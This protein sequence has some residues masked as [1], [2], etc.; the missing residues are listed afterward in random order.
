M[1]ILA[2]ENSHPLVS[3]IFYGNYFMGVLGILLSV[4]TC[5]QLHL[6]LNDLPFYLFLLTSVLFYYTYSYQQSSFAVKK[7]NPRTVWYIRHHQYIQWAQYI[8]IVILAV[9]TVIS[10][11]YYGKNIST[12]PLHLWVFTTLILL[13]AVLYYGLLP[14]KIW[15]INL[16]N[17]GWFKAFTIG[18]VWAGTVSIFPVIMLYLEGKKIHVEMPLLY[19]YFMKNFMFCTVNAIMFDLKDF[20]DDSNKDLLTFV[21]RFGIERTKYFILLPLACLGII[22]LTGFNYYEQYP[23]WHY[24]FNLIPF[25]LLIWTICSVDKNKT[26][27]YY[28]VIIDGLL[29]IKA[30]CG[31]LSA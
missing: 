11:Q 1:S 28:L 9:L 18:F 23:K 25:L 20:E 22:A 31:I 7:P 12:V 13:A 29:V 27:L 15:H 21:V 30:I 2:Q 26:I 10:F 4:E 24:W 19:W 17:T 8:R 3:F 5:F 6:P 14:G 16:R